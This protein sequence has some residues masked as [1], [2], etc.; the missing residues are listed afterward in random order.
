[1]VQRLYTFMSASSQ[2]LEILLECS[3]HGQ[4]H[5]RW[6][7]SVDAVRPIAAHLPSILRSIEGASKL[8]LSPEAQITVEYLYDYFNSFTAVIM[9]A[10]WIKVLLS[11]DRRSKVSQARKATIDVE[12]KNLEL[13]LQDLK[14]LR[15]GWSDILREAKLVAESMEINPNLPVKRKR[16]HKQF[17]DETNEA[18]ITQPSTSLVESSEETEFCQN[19]FYNLMDNVISGIT[20]LFKH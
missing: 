20:E 11:I 7:E 4:S 10:V 14:V 12:V 2:C 5:T 6:S 8:N 3:L 1:M 18:E 15:E 13:L 19:V 17:F 16:K 9:S